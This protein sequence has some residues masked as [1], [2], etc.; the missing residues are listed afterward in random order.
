MNKR[1]AAIAGF[2]LFSLSIFL[3]VACSSKPV[4]KIDFASSIDSTANIEDD[5]YLWAT[6]KWANET[7]I[8]AERSRYGAFEIL[9][10]QN[11]DLL[12]ELMNKAAANKEAKEGSNMF[13]VGTFYSLAL[14][15]DKVNS[16][17]Y[18]PIKGEL[19]RIDKVSDKESLIKELAHMHLY[20]SSPAFYFFS[21]QDAKNSSMVMARVYQG[22]LGLPD[23]DY[24]TEEDDHSKEVRTKYVEHMTNMFK[25]IGYSEE[26]AASNAENV[27]NFETRL[28][29][30]SLTR[31]ESRNPQKTYNKMTLTE[32]KE[33]MPSFNWDIFLTELGVPNPGD[34]NV[35][36]PDFMKEVSVMVDDVPLESWQ[37][38]MKWKVVDN[39][40]PYLSKDF[41]DEN[42][43]FNGKFLNGTPEMLP[44]WK[45][46]LNATNGVLGEVVGQ[47]YVEKNFPPEAKARA[48]KIVNN[49]TEVLNERIK[50]LDWMSNETKEKALEKLAAFNVKIGYPDKWRDYSG[51]EIKNDSYAANIM[52]SNYFDSKFDY[53]KIGKPVDRDEWGMTPQTVNA[54]YHPIL[55]EI[56]FPAAILQPPFFY[57]DADDAANYGAMGCVIGHEITHGFDDQG[58]QY[59]ADG[60]L[61]DWWTEEDSRKFDVKAK[62][63]IDQYNGYEALE[64][65]FVDGDLTQGE[66]IAD[67]GGVTIA[68]NAFKTTEQ[69]KANDEI[70]GFTPAQRFFLSYAT[71]WKSKIR[72]ENLKLRLKTDVHSPAHYRVIGPLSNIPEFAEAFGIKTGTPMVKAEEERIFIW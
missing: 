43:A 48:K 3:L 15:E 68:F 29:E 67:L 50:Q 41:V 32:V 2:A 37:K 6:G 28:A 14:D 69:Y 63:I 18:D 53:S 12:K 47:V 51:L 54:Y 19:E 38:Y 23:R 56:V 16:Q 65:H 4:E 34:I 40:A 66:N 13:K 39:M 72:D 55:N 1:Y 42:F 24:Y 9:I 31:K 26:D 8:P 17:G 20:T 30:A 5:F 71:V 61:T 60:N 52:R 7:E 10:D 46:A 11:Y 59:A 49:L 64:G 36:M 57:K 35:S 33:L 44:R 62:Q 45:R 22:G 21:S 25:L 70:D 58:R 27:M